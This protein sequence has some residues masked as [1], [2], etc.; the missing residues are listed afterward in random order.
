MKKLIDTNLHLTDLEK[1]TLNCIIGQGSQIIC[2][3]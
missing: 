2:L 3:I 1:E